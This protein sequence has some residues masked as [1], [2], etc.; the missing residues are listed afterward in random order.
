[1]FWE[2]NMNYTSLNFYLLLFLIVIVY[3]TLPLKIRWFALLVGSLSFYYIISKQGFVILLATTLATYLFG[4]LIDGS[5]NKTVARI[6]LMIAVSV[7][8]I[9][10]F[11]IKTSNFVMRI[12]DVNEVS[13]IVP[14]GISFYSLQMIAYIVD[15]YRG[16]IKP[17]KN[18]L[19]YILFIS[20]FPQI[21]QG[22]IPRYGALGEQL[23]EGHK[24]D[25]E[26]I[27]KGIHLIIWGFFLK[28]MIADKAGVV[29]NNIFDNYELY[30]G[31]YVVVGG[32]LYSIQL[33]T[34]FMA[35]TTISKGVSEIFGIHLMD[36]FDHPYMAVS[37]KD[38]WRRWHQSLSTWLRDY[39]YIP[40]GGNRKGKLMKY[41]N[42]LV[43]FF[44]SG[45]WH[46]ADYNYIVWGLLHGVYQ[47]TG[48]LTGKIK[49]KIYDKLRM[50]EEIAVRRW[51]QR[52]GTFIWVT[53]AW[54]IFR[55][56]QL[57]HAITMIKSI[58]TVY[59]PWILFDDSLLRLGLSWKEWCVLVLSVMLLVKVSK[60]Q[61]EVCIRDR[62][63]S[64]HIIVRWFIYV[65]AISVI[66]VFGTYG[67]G[68]DVKDF[69]YG[70]F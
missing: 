42:L 26:G 63:L 24:F 45:I 34:D 52:A 2:S 37:I 22:P 44:V 58:F 51:I 30:P 25:E 66:W 18:I 40:L 38:F 65:A 29:V 59:N 43:T 32:V 20:F 1:M 68:F 36:N 41:I 14:V 70:G 10:L 19:K 56:D 4:I 27:T 6:H 61:E 16:N 11:A 9:P 13:W 55:A 7:C 17:Q 46:G 35:C 8:I 3:Y 12:F 49:G 5:N 48:E 33:Y 54:I 23:F 15:L 69:I 31:L 39:V 60:K 28:F 21:I 64:Q 67:Y 57:G 53:L 50:P 47:I 62:I